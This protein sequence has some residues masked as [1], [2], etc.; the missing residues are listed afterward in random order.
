VSVKVRIAPS[1]T[2]RLQIGNL[3]T[4]LVNWLYARHHGGKFLLRI[5][6]TDLERST[7]ESDQAIQDDL[8]WLGLNWDEFAR[9]SERFDRYGEAIEKLKADGRLY[10][11]YETEEELGLK[12]KS[13]LGQGRPPVYDRAALR[14]SAADRA[15]L[16][17]RGL[18]PH[19]RFLLKDNPITWRDG[20]RG[21]VTIPVHDL[22]DP[23]LIRA[24]GSLLYTLASCVD[25]IDF[26]ITDVIR[27]EDHVTNTAAQI[28]IIEAL[29]SAAPRFAHLPLLTDDEGQKLSKRF[30]SFGVPKLREE[31]GLEPLAVWCH[32][33]RLGSSLP[34]EAFADIEPLV[35]SF[36]LGAFSR[37]PPK[38]D[39]EELERL[40]ARVLHLLSFTQVQSRLADIGLAGADE[41]FWLAVRTNITHMAQARDW[42]HVS[43][44]QVAG[45]IADVSFATAAADLLP[46]EPWNETTWDS[47]VSELKTKTGRKGKELFMPLRLALT[48][49]EHG[50]EL[51][52]L[53]PLLG[54]K[55][56]LHRL[57][58]KAA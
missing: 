10:P 39:V 5:D 11:C 54:R 19:W 25:D 20:V 3:R 44:E 27:G 16:E 47:W 9:Q 55:R 4:A 38:F 1:P 17:A 35:K 58:G 32:L 34:I 43:R 29:G 28:Q 12:R 31:M 22:S 6:D 45:T 46:P 56:V 40:N 8:R 26:A 49:R 41:H 18:K 37:N 50:P 14:L 15:A 7:K 23:V 42:W 53:L 48:G 57:Q 24:D 2:G 33:A 36:D 30:G 13:L 21:D 52:V 51:K